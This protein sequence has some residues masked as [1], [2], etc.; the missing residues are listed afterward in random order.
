MEDLTGRALEL[1]PDNAEALTGLGL[2][3]IDS[4]QPGNAIAQFRKPSQRIVATAMPTWDW[5]K[6]TAAEGAEA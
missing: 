5:P 2:C 4:E 1:K 3:Y 6:P